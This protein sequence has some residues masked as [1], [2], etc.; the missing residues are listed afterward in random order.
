MG[1]PL[2]DQQQ[3]FIRFLEKLGQ[4][5]RTIEFLPSDDEIAE[6]RTKALH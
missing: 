5:N 2:L 6:R 1:A 4:L 3:R